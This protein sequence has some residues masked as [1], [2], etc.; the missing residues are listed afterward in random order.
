[1][2]FQIVNTLAHHTPFI[3]LVC[4]LILKHM[5][6]T[7]AKFRIALDRYKEEVMEVSQVICK[8]YV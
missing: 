4:L 8:Q 1:M 5:Q 3:A 7:I 6:D 2:N